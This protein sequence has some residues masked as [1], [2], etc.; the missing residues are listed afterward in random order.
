MPSKRFKRITIIA[1]VGIATLILAA[2]V[3]LLSLDFNRFKPLIVQAVREATG[4]DVVLH[5]DIKV[6][7]GFKLNV[8]INDLE[9][10]NDAWAPHPE[11]ATI[12]RCELKLALLRLIRGFVEIDRLVFIEPNVLLETDASGEMNVRVKN[13]NRQKKSSGEIEDAA[14][15]LPVREVQVKRGRLAYKDGPSGKTYTVNVEHLVL[16]ASDLRSP[17]QMEI[18]VLLNGRPLEVEGTLG[19]PAAFMDSNDPWTVNLTAKGEGAVARVQGSI[20]EVTKLRGM[21]LKTHAEGTSISRALSLA[22]IR[23]PPDLG[24][25][26][27]DATICDREGKLSLTPM[28]LLL[29]TDKLALIRISGT[30]DNLL[31]PHGIHLGFTAQCKD[32]SRLSRLSRKPLPLRGPLTMS[33]KILDSEPGIFSVS[34]LRIVLGDK[35]IIGSVRLDL[36]GTY[37]R[38]TIKLVCQELDLKN[39]LPPGLGES[40]WVYILKRMGFIDLK[41]SVAGPYGRPVVEELDLHAGNRDEAAL[42]VKGAIKNPL[43][44]TGIEAHFNIQ[45]KDAADLEKLF[46]KPVPLRGPFIVSGHLEDLAQ[47]V[48]ASDDL[49]VSLGKNEVAGLMDLN[50]AGEKPQ[51]DATLSSQELE[52]FEGPSFP[53]AGRLGDLY[54]RSSWEARGRRG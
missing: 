31:A 42:T 48:F 40:T 22:G 20:K 5:G 27:L 21:S 10:R 54:F 50:M 13:I 2:Y 47:N 45:G 44:M 14:P 16:T 30:V 34:D 1:L 9:I 12:K 52:F 15:I 25:F 32:L 19:S 53:G 29:G 8:V 28:N 38:S 39:V 33:G 7:L 4:L 49:Q 26:S 11:I 37:P 23:V 3:I 35:S 41:L 18:N 17:V 43:T 6:K 36:A 51:L 46:G 24:P